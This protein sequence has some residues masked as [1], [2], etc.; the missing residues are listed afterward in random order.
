M[1]IHLKQL[2]SA[3]A[4]AAI[5][6]LA[7]CG[8]SGGG[9]GGAAAPSGTTSV[10]STIIDGAIRNALVCVDKNLNGACDAGET[11]GRTD[12]AGNVTMAVPNGDVGLYPILA[13]VGTDAV[14]VDN[15]PVATAYSLSAPPGKPAVVSPLTTMVQQA[16]SAGAT[17]SEA[18]KSVQGTTGINV[19]LFEDFTKAAAPTDGSPKAADVARMI[20]V[21][22]QAQNKTLGGLVDGTTISL[23]DL[24]AAVQKRL[25][26]ILP[27]LVAELQN[28]PP[29]ANEQPVAKAAREAAVVAAITAN[30]PT[31]LL[32]VASLPTTVAINQQLV[33]DAAAPVTAY[34]PAAGAS[35]D[36]LNFTD[37]Q[38]WFIRLFSASLA[39]ATQDAN[40]LT[41]FVERRF[42]NNAGNVAK[43]SFGGN[44]QDQSDLHWN[45]STWVACQVAQENSQTVRDAAGNN[46]YNYCDSYSTG[47][48]TRATFDL[49][50]KKMIDV[51]NQVVTA[52][53]TN[54]FIANA[55]TQ[56]GA[57]S[58]PAGANLFYQQGQ[59]LTK[60]FAYYPG[61]G[62][63]VSHLSAAILAGG[64]ASTQAAGTGCNSPG[65]AN[66]TAPLIGT[67]T[68]EELVASFKGT[69]CIFNQETLV[70]NGVSLPGD[71]TNSIGGVPTVSIGTVGSAPVVATPTSYFTGNQW[72]RVAFTG[73]GTNAVTYYTCKQRQITGSPR[74]CTSIGSGAYNIT[75]MADGSR[76][77]TFTNPPP[78]TAP[79]TYNR[80]FVERNGLVRHG[81]QDKNPVYNRAR[82][83][84]TAMLAL[85]TQLNGAPAQFDPELP[86][87]LTA[88]SYQGTWDMRDAANA[89]DPGQTVT[90]N[91]NGTASCQDNHPPVAS[92]ACTVTITN[93]ATGAFTFHGQNPIDPTGTL[94]FMTGTGSGTFSDN[95]V[96][97]PVLKQFVATRR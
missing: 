75:A 81:F 68:L 11:Q 70:V 49:N 15:G 96:I 71:P 3:L 92:F 42:R 52:G 54:L 46:S 77:M 79:L 34:V 40:G 32:T 20:V 93:P 82:L 72:I 65:F 30:S 17:L 53:Y 63:V 74:S 43:W 45:G 90:F 5:I 31:P 26:E 69:P 50:G 55:A 18:E 28:N 73:N 47:R 6:T 95:S 76:V 39:Q 97:P 94:N 51:Y 80:V 1:T 61:T 85:L 7:G 2:A 58:F 14:D 86:Q 38:N 25:L 59:D 56:L 24:N 91:G 27:T 78:Q 8:G 12:A 29:P 67:Q 10:S 88:A 89:A 22:T 13:Q 48:G 23:A 64:V 16:M 21:T 41:R 66:G 44:P 4:G 37:A 9:G 19:S 60:A 57:A 84:T 62:S 83:N 33:K 35:L 87:T 36:T